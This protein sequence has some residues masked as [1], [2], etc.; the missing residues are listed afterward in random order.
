MKKKLSLLMAI[1]MIFGSIS[2]I[3]APVFAAST[4]VYSGFVLNS[5]MSG[6]IVPVVGPDGKIYV[7]DYNSGKIY[8]MDIDGSNKIDFKTG[9]NQ[10]IGLAFDG[11]GNLIVA[12]HAGSKIGKLD[13]SA[14]YTSIKNSGMGLL[15]GTAI[16]SNGKIFTVDYSNGRVYK[17][18]ADG[19]NFTT[20]ATGFTTSSI[21]GL[22]I[23]GS[24]NLYVSDRSNNKISKITSAGTVSTFATVTSPT[25]V[26]MGEDGYLYASSGSKNIIKLDLSANVI[27]TITTGTLSAWGTYI[28]SEGY[29]LFATLGSSLH[30][31]V[32]KADTTTTT[33][34][35]VSMN[36]EIT[37]SVADPTAFS[38]TGIASNPQVTSAIVS[39][40]SI[41]LTLNAAI[42]YTD[43]A[44]KVNYSK[45]G[46]NNLVVYGSAVEFGNFTGMPVANN[47][48]KVN[49]ITSISPIT[50]AYG[51]SMSAISL[52]TTATLVL[53]DSTTSSAAVT[54]D[55][56]TPTFDGNTSGTYSFSGTVELSSNVTNPSNLKATVSVIV[57]APAA[58]PSISSVATIST[59]TVANGTAL[60]AVGLP[61]SV[62]VTLS[63]TTTGAAI[64]WDSGTPTYNGNVAG[65]YSFSG[66]LTVGAG[67]TNTGNL[68]ASV[69]VIVQAPSALPT[70]S[71]VA[72]LSN[73]T[74]ANG[75]ALNAVGLPSSVIVT[76]SDT[77]TTGAAITW[78]NGTPT[79]NGN[80]AGTYSFSGTLTVGAGITNTSNLA[81]SVDV[82]VQAVSTTEKESNSSSPSSTPNQPTTNRG[83]D[84]IVNGIKASAGQENAIVVGGRLAKELVVDAKTVDSMIDQALKILAE[85]TGNITPASNMV[86]IPVTTTSNDV[87][88]IK[89]T[90][91]IVKRLDDNKFSIN[92][93]TSKG[94]FIL[95]AKE[96]K[97]AEI[98]KNFNLATDLQ[99]IVVDV[100]INVSIPAVSEM[101][102][103][104]IKANGNMTVVSQPLEFKITATS[105][106]TKESIEIS[107]FTT[108][109]EREVLLP[110][111][112]DTTKITT[113]VLIEPNG[114]LRHIPTRV[115]T[116]DNNQYAN[117]QSLTNSDYS[118]I[119]NPIEVASVKGHWAQTAVND[120]ASR[121]IIDEPEKFEPNMKI[122]RGD[123]ATMLTK[124][125][126]I[127]RTDGPA[128]KFSDVMK[129]DKNAVGIAFASEYNL[130][131]GY[132]DGSFKPDQQISRQEAMVILAKAMKLADISTNENATLSNFADTSMIAAWAKDAAIKVT[133]ANVMNGIGNNKLGPNT[134]L[135]AAEA[136]YAVRNLLV[137]GDM[138]NN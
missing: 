46:T 11:S 121:M 114:M 106:E 27:D 99:K 66:S 31:I 77:T 79:Y 110:A 104:V 53:S 6:G 67:I 55:G 33:K 37:G 4:P 45:S 76:L 108:Y 38:F 8:K 43:T 56:G 136:A 87:I 88:T 83:A 115:F 44:I 127:Y 80:V 94:N 103:N 102:N 1:M 116:V 12:E 124:A 60:N 78:N 74:V 63:D 81:A 69:D 109:V 100:Q 135:T 130:I 58:L 95:P 57:Q 18:D 54:W 14:N 98:A 3:Q 97:I 32:G 23:D 119:Y 113:G 90:G 65:T 105:S 2:N 82:I 117:I 111:N 16:D 107:K 22:C 68:T 42:A 28:S 51:T 86:R 48:K 29:I 49:S 39:G 101:F 84:V 92:I 61:S 73:I 26:S 41:E 50:V 21:I 123:F 24:D 85:S 112:T 20:F 129:T 13:T 126:G 128:I 133:N 15:T 30:R 34:V 118:V 132:A 75:T 52:P 70:I 138:I 134:S 17:M 59:I 36:K 71:S 5:S 19:S 25:W 91:D 122:T 64:T 35:V 9:L 125:L 137:K 47:V 93:E 89:L 72:T 96:M 10:P 131:S 62:I 120:L 40:S 7:S